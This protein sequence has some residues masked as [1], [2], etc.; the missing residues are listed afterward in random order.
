MT[1][2]EMDG[3]AQAGG[4]CNFTRQGARVGFEINVTA[5]ARAGLS[6]SSRL[7]ALARIVREEGDSS[8][9]SH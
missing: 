8:S 9:T 6:L 5:A 7:L 3:F 1:V 2:G 4:V